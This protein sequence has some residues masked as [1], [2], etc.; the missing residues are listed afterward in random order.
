MFGNSE[1]YDAV[2]N[3][4]GHTHIHEM[5]L[6]EF[7]AKLDTSHKGLTD[8][9]IEQKLSEYGENKL[10]EK[11]KTPLIFKLLKQFINFFAILMWV[12][13]GLAFFAETVSPGEGNLYIGF[14]LVGVVLLNGL[15][16][17]FQEFKAEKALESFNNMLPPKARV[18]RNNKEQEIL[19]KDLV[20]GDLIILSEGD[21]IPADARVIE[22]A[23]LK[24]NNASLTGESEPQLRSLNS[25]SNNLLE[26]RNI[27]FSG[28]TV[29][30]G[31]GKAIIYA[32]GMKT[33]LGKIADLTTSTN[34]EQT[35]IHKE[36]KKFIRLIS[37][38]AIILGVS[39]FSI[40][41]VSGNDFWMSMVF[42]I[43][44]IVAN[45]PE[46][47][48]PTVTLGLSM[49]AQKMAKKKALVKQLESVETLGSTT[50]I[51]TDKTGTLTQNKMSVKSVFLNNKNYSSD[52]LSKDILGISPLM[53]NAVLC[54]NS[55]LTDDNIVLGDPTEAALI[56]EAN[57]HLGNKKDYAWVRQKHRR[58]FEDPFDSKTKRM[59]TVNEVE[60]EKIAFLK[61][62]LES[63]FKKCDRIMINGKI[64]PLNKQE[65]DVI[66]KQN[67]VYSERGERVLA[68]ASKKLDGHSFE[69]EIAEGGFVFNGLISMR[70]PPRLE[71]KDAIADCKTAGIKI[72]VVSGDYPL[73]IKAISKEIGLF[74]DPLMIT[75][76]ELRAMSHTQLITVF[77]SNEEIIFAR[78]SPED[79]RR[80]V[81]VLQ[82]LGEIV[83]V[84]GDG[85]NDAPALK[86][87]DIGVA[88]GITGTDVAKE[89]SDM[90]LMDDN[91]ATIVKAI[92]EGRLIF[93]NLKKS[94]A[95]TLTSNIPEIA[96]FIAFVLLGIPLPL[97]V[98]LIL[99]IDLG[100]D[101]IPAISLGRESAETDI[102]K[103]P[104]RSRTERLVGRNL[105]LFSY[106][107][108]GV[109]QAIAGF[110]AY[111]YVLFRGG[112]HFGET[113]VYSNPLYQTAIGAFFVT[114]IICQIADV[115]IS[116]VRRQS[117]FTK[118]L[119]ENKMLLVGLLVE[120]SLTY[121]IIYTP[122]GNKFFN[123]RPLGLYEYLIAVPF[124]LLIFFGDE[125]RKYYLR[126]DNEFVKKWL[127]Y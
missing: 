36:I 106:G 95:Y 64:L 105:I 101:L 3:K 8:K 89:A 28:T 66:L 109:I 50:V 23:S 124:A 39:F 18:I 96:P 68:F 92:E 76:D 114:I 121:I 25:T 69:N 79:K 94:I 60:G 45:V 27:V 53:L 82:E 22:M 49:A 81:S 6:E 86:K 84:T 20:P 119:L 90:I 43:G 77:K 33:Q 70:D 29:S 54:N 73:T 110:C 41:F 13:A 4:Q 9:Q 14:A 17:F 99:A 65:K 38:I 83:A 75:G 108:I 85:V 40:G 113:L 57:K 61:G 19:A 15:F 47:L 127:D 2:S 115:F 88:M 58:L 98:A 63:V 116:K 122:F 51:C 100:T 44:I 46:G 67:N 62:A 12:G 125:V 71:V 42:A 30:A 72:I 112:W 91:F 80:I 104:P 37:I 97:T 10:A 87:A 1:D 126:K 123:T 93:D 56:L 48:L 78:S 120:I 24:V 5:S 118:N 107:I 31:S 117:I 55:S 32:T 34:D 7:F 21:K 52:E 59:I 16:T 111:F 35:P 26:T 11:K 74:D 103:R 102:M